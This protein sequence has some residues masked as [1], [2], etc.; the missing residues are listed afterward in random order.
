M[1]RRCWAP[2]ARLLHFSGLSFPSPENRV[3]HSSALHRAVVQTEEA[4]AAVFHFGHTSVPPL[5]LDIPL[6][7]AGSEVIA[8]GM[9]QTPDVPHKIPNVV[10]IENHTDSSGQGA[11]SRLWG[12]AGSLTH[13]VLLSM[14]MEATLVRRN[15]VAQPSTLTRSKSL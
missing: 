14:L 9:V 15:S 7:G 11:L 4:T 10:K 12:P 5:V 8:W 1:V 6:P 3:S 13:V 2:L